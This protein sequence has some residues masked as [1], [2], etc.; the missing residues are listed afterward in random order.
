MSVKLVFM[1]KPDIILPCRNEEKGIRLCISSIKKAI[2]EHRLRAE[3]IVSDS[4]TDRS[5]DIARELGAKVIKHNK[6]GYGAACLEGFK[7]AKGEYILFADADGSY[8]F[9]NI[10]IFLDYLHKEYDL[11]IGNRFKGEIE[12]GSMPWL[13][14]HIGNPLLSAVLRIFFNTKIQDAH[15]GMRAIKRRAFEQLELRTTGM[16]FASELIVKAIK[17]R[18]RIKEVNINYHRRKGNSKLRSFSDGWRHLRFMFMYAPD[19]L[20]IL[21][22]LLFFVLG[23]LIIARFVIAPL[24]IGGFTFYMYPTLVGSFL[25][26]LGYQV[27]ILG[28]SA[29]AYAV[30]EGFE[31]KDRLVDL[32]ARFVSF[33]SGII[34][35]SIFLLVSFFLALIQIIDWVSKGYPSMQNNNMMILT[36]TLSIIGVQTLFSAFFMSIL[37][38]NKK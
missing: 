7:A 9:E 19:Y 20:F 5:P 8:D 35:G 16:E 24:N 13:H 28:I 38:V 29:K 37:L 22:G 1:V 25:A 21:P 32:L 17:K 14:K 30:S 36:L 10:F 11:V 2:S 26:V 3:I 6:K 34:F 33:E 18:M 27:I 12:R 23:S 15:C 31:E 4:S